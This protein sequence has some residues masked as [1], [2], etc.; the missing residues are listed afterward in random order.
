MPIPSRFGSPPAISSFS[1]LG[2]DRMYSSIPHPE[3]LMSTTV[4]AAEIPH[5]SPSTVAGTPTKSPARTPSTPIV[6]QDDESK[7][8]KSRIKPTKTVSLSII[9]RSCSLTQVK[10]S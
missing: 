4:L 8:R 9:G 7:W 2:S 3:A 1:E 5:S 6:R 10:L